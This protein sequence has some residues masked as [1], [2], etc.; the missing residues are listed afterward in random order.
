MD[1]G[2]FLETRRANSFG[3]RLRTGF[4]MQIYFGVPSVTSDPHTHQSGN[5]LSGRIITV[6]TAA[7]CPGESV[8]IDRN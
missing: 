8:P 2:S 4:L 1:T 3:G 5:S 6:S 7:C